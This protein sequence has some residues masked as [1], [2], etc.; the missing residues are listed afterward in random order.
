MIVDLTG[1]QGKITWDATKP[2]GQPRRMLDT[3]RARNEFGFQAKTGFREGLQK[4]IAW[5]EENHR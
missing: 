1:F 3:T 5:Y 4:T 2:D